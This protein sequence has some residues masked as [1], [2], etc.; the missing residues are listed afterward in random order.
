MGYKWWSFGE[1]GKGIGIVLDGRNMDLFLKGNF[2]M[3]KWN[4][5]LLHCSLCL[6]L[7]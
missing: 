3:I 4:I 6:H 5:L 2:N 7:P 1:T